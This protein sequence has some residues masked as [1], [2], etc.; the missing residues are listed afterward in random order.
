MAS[1]HAEG[2]N[3]SIT[4]SGAVATC[5]VWLRPDLSMAEGAECATAI[6]G[7]LEK[8]AVDPDVVGVVF[9]VSEGPAIAGPK[10]EAALGAM[11]SRFERAGRRI[12]IVT[13]DN[14]MQRMQQTRITGAHAPQFGRVVSTALEGRAYAEAPPSSRRRG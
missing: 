6:A 1:V 2:A 9:D 10:T 12:A 4:L 8:L 3:Y 14:A 5:R 13:S 7:H 11:L